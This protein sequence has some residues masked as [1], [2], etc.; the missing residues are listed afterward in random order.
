M[1]IG[2]DIQGNRRVRSYLKSQFYVWCGIWIGATWEALEK[3][4]MERNVLKLC[5]DIILILIVAFISTH[6]WRT[7]TAALKLLKIR[8]L[9]H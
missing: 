8:I 1:A 3:H 7:L 5:I 4:F 9:G 6:V 2:Q